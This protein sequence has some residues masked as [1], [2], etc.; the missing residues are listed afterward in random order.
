MAER[1]PP[2]LKPPSVH[3]NPAMTKTT[4]PPKPASQPQQEPESL[5]TSR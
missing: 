2:A 3:V 4:D 5:G 1:G